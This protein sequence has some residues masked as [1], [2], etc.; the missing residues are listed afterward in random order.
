MAQLMG[1]DWPGN[2]R[3]LQNVLENAIVLFRSKVIE[4]VEMSER[5]GEELPAMN[6]SINLPLPEWIKE[7]EKQYLMGKLQVAGGRIDLTAK[8]SGVDVRTIH[9]KMKLYGLDKKV[10]QKEISRN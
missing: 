9:R 7:Q 8:I 1:H 5:A 6:A 3:E 10:Y 2:V 4:E